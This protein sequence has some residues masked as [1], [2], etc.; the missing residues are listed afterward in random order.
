MLGRA[1]DA[2]VPVGLGTE[3]SSSPETD[4]RKDSR[5]Y[6]HRMSEGDP[7]GAPSPRPPLTRRIGAL[8]GGLGPVAW[9][10]V[11]AAVAVVLLV[12]S[13]A[14]VSLGQPPNDDPPLALLAFGAG[15]SLPLAVR[16]RRPV[17]VLV[18][19]VACTVAAALLG[20]R[21]T[22]FGSNAG[23]AIGLAMYTVA[24]RFPRKISLG[25]LGGVVAA[26]FA[27]AWI[28]T[29]LH[30]AN[31]NAV[32]VVAAVAG[33]FV[34]DAVR[35][36]REYRAELADRRRREHEERT[37][38][39]IA[40]ERLQISREVHDVVSHNL[41]VIAVRSGVGRML[42]DTRPDEARTALAEVEAVSREA[43]GE[44]RWLLGTVR[45][46]EAAAPA[47]RLDD[48]PRLV[49]QVSASGTDVTL[50]RRGIPAGLPATL[51][52]SAYRIVQEALTNVVKH[53]GRT[54]THVILEYGDEGLRIEVID[55]GN[56][57]GLPAPATGGGWG[58]VGIRERA[59][60]FGGTVE[61]GPRRDGGFRISVRFPVI[62]PAGDGEDR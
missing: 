51:E 19:V 34:G 4:G 30:S 45:D 32:H 16:R 27:A 53:A 61:A 25:A 50:E 36:H 24:E 49:E 3:T 2:T 1:A 23:P 48:L 59:A 11:D 17:T 10:R 18:I 22:P 12:G 55:D 28:A 35:V 38:R 14:P 54:R 58:I 31:E 40:E 43:L 20:I 29:W 41:S 52:L 7:G 46:H 37:R 47:P 21:F 62:E 13:I 56:G 33:W 39:A 26:T 44:L 9:R 8:V 57:D 5:R 6:G 42:F 15:T 60:L